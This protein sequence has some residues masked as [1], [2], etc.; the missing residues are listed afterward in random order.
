MTLPLDPW[1]NRGGLFDFVT[2]WDDAPFQIVKLEGGEFG[3]LELG[4]EFH[5]GIRKDG[6][7]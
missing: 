5:R 7:E 4:G 2:R 3:K 1:E 6:G